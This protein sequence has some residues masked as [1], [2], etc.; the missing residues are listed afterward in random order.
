MD[1]TE[2]L[3]LA[4]GVLTIPTAPYHEHGVRAFVEEYCREMGLKPLRDRVGNVIVKTGNGR[5]PLV[6]VAHMDHPGFEIIG[7]N[8]AEFLGSAPREMFVGS[9]V[10]VF[11]R[12]G[13]ARVTVK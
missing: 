2:L 10:K 8:R 13:T 6:F 5:V 4:R 12:D 9:R 7:R 1:R 11:G 3:K